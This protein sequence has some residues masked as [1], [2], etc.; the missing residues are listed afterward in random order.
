MPPSVPKPPRSP[1]LT[2]PRVGDPLFVRPF[3]LL[4]MAATLTIVTLHVNGFRSVDKRAAVFRWLQS[5]PS[6]PDVVCLQE[7]HCVSDEECRL[8]FSAT[9]FSSVASLGSNHSCGCV[10]LYR[11]YLSFVRSWC[12][13]GGRFLLCEFLFRGKVFRVACVY[14][15]NDTSSWMRLGIGLTVGP[16][17]SVWGF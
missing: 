3:L 1:D 16:N 12:D 6:L 9:G 15:P 5:L 8:W 14:A 11:P 7:A 10:V 2:A 13:D 17:V 4:L